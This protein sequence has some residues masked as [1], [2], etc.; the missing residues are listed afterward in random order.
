MI[1]A[2]FFDNDGVLVSTERIVFEANKQV[3]SSMGVSYDLND[4]IASTVMTNQGSHGFLRSKGHNEDFIEKF[5]KTR[6]SVWDK[7]LGSF[8]HSIVG[9]KAALDQLGNVDFIVTTS[10]KRSQFLRS[11][12]NTNLLSY[13]QMIV[14]REDYVNIKPEP[15][16]YL[17]A[18]EKSG[19]QA[20]EVLVV[21]D[22]PRGVAA[23]NAASLRVAAIPHDITTGLDF[24]NADY[25]LNNISEL[26]DLVQSFD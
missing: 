17:L 3:L 16:V 7:E 21:E 2:V 22:T 9:V 10:A 4:F 15:D 12:T 18:L 11:H 20:N 24:S 25:V 26:V 5:S 6:Q 8:D 23:A 13:F 14:A 19:Y 1:K